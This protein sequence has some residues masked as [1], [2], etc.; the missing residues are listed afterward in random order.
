MPERKFGIFLPTFWPN[1]GP[2]S[3][4]QAMRDV[5]KAAEELGFDPL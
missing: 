1:F 2:Y 3:T 5:A 4:A